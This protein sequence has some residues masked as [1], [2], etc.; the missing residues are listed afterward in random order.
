MLSHQ[1]IREL[2]SFLTGSGYPEA[3]SS[4]RGDAEIHLQRAGGVQP[5]SLLLELFHTGHGVPQAA[6]TNLLGARLVTEL[7]A[8]GMLQPDGD[9][10]ASSYRISASEGLLVVHD[11]FPPRHAEDVLG[12]NPS[13]RTLASLTMGLQFDTALD[14]GTGC[15]YQALLA[16]RHSRRVVAT[17]ILPRALTLTALN[18]QLNQMTNIECR[19]GNF[20]EPVVDEHFDLVVCNPPFIISPDSGYTFRDSGLAGD[21]VS[22]SVVRS[23]A[24]HLKPGGFATVLV[25][26]GVNEAQQWDEP[27]RR[28]LA[29]SGCDAILVR[30]GMPDPLA[31]AAA[32]NLHLAQQDPE[33]YRQNLSRWSAHLSQLGFDRVTQVGVI[34]RRRTGH[35]WIAPFEASE[36]PSGAAG[37]QLERMFAAQ[38]WLRLN[39]NDVLDQQ[40]ALVEGH[41]LD[42]AITF[43]NGSYVIQN[44]VMRPPEGLGLTGD[45][46]PDLMPLLFDLPNGTVRELVKSLATEMDIET[47]TMARAAA[48]VRRLLERGLIELDSA[49]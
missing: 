6:A 39:G 3:S 1:A 36:P 45:I 19:E 8:A 25:N 18:A 38:D 28:W 42:Q 27:G 22:R 4:K 13:T 7:V 11:P 48:V 10:I 12:L 20:F 30:Y 2:H 41:R 9:R 33:A 26:W 46:P 14:V 29:D 24:D 43:N 40:F 34:M 49:T 23:A 5:L 44:A 32:A 47:G 37:A 17:D 16:A 31:Y 15:G 21:E 35:N